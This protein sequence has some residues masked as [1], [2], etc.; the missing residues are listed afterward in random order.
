[1]PGQG[2]FAVSWLA[3]GDDGLHNLRL[4]S[5]FP[6]C[7]SRPR[8]RQPPTAFAGELE[9]ANK[10]K[11]LWGRLSAIFFKPKAAEEEEEEDEGRAEPRWQ[12]LVMR[13]YQKQFDEAEM[14]Q[15]DA[16]LRNALLE[17][18]VG[19]ALREESV[20][21]SL[22]KGLA[23]AEGEPKADISEI[24]RLRSRTN[25]YSKRAS[26]EAIAA[27]NL[28]QKTM[29]QM[30][31]YDDVMLKMAAN[32]EKIQEDLHREEMLNRNQIPN[33]P[34]R[35][36]YGQVITTEE[37]CRKEGMVWKAGS[38]C[39]TDFKNPPASP[40]EVQA[41]A[42]VQSSKK[43]ARKLED[44]MKESENA[45]K[46]AK[47]DYAAAK[48]KLDDGKA[49]GTIAAKEKAAEAMLARTEQAADKY[50]QDKK[51]YEDVLKK[52]LD[53]MSADQ[54]ITE[55]EKTRAGKKVSSD[56]AAQAEAD[57]KIWKSMKDMAN[58]EG[59]L[60]DN[61]TKEA[62]DMKQDQSMAHT[63]EK[64]ELLGHMS[65]LNEDR[66]KYARVAAE[67][68][69]GQPHRSGSSPAVALIGLQREHELRRRRKRGCEELRG[70]CAR[71]RPR[72]SG[73]L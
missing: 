18:K 63:F 15:T 32:I 29:Q 1:M 55:A 35:D 70:A 33:S 62:S 22:E 41:D 3:I 14:Q 66:A 59:H 38:G 17:R 65:K 45:L 9:D 58:A 27:N 42:L 25:V 6:S 72:M 19:R 67:A 7:S 56:Q 31:F 20:W 48:A 34:A 39:F 37:A 51:A 8:S 71:I 16:A 26:I 69:S 13:F 47:D 2:R 57:R 28:R 52:E 54:K 68:L 73:F 60:A 5:N 24:K 50:S 30:A 64:S 61:Y 53:A 4:P 10:N 40:A 12:G 43:E 21:S 11:G 36:M 46:D 49:P 23:E 44:R